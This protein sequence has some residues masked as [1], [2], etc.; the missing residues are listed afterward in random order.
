MNCTVTS[1]E[2]WTWNITMEAYLTNSFS[3]LQWGALEL[4]KEASNNVYSLDLLPNSSCY[5]P[6]LRPAPAS[7][8]IHVFNITTYDGVWTYTGGITINKPCSSSL[9][10]YETRYASCA[11]HISLNIYYTSVDT[12]GE[13]AS[14]QKSYPNQ[15]RL[16][17]DQ[18]RNEPNVQSF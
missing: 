18:W 7:T 2:T 3:L 17:C 4:F 11:F 8:H 6:W 16:T 10:Y 13:T 1:N 5:N 12:G 14:V 9:Y 15:C